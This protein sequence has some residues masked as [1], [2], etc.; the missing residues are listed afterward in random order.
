MHPDTKWCFYRQIGDETTLPKRGSVALVTARSQAQLFGVVLESIYLFCGSKG[1]VHA[2]DFLKCY[3]RYTMWLQ[4]LPP[5]IKSVDVSSQPLP[6]VLF[7][8]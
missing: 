3:K 2:R 4:N 1:M 8:Q 6:H 5:E 7:L